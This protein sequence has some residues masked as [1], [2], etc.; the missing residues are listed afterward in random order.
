MKTNAARILD[1]LG[2]QYRLVEYPVDEEDLS[3]EKVA[4]EMGMPL[5][6][7][8]KTLVCRAAG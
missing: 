1:Q 3:A 5:D 8:W 7:V 4:R 2:I 6:P